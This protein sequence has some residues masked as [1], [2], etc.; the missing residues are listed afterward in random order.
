MRI[1]F[2][3]VSTRASPG[4]RPVGRPF[5]LTRKQVLLEA[6]RKGP[7]GTVLTATQPRTVLPEGQSGDDGG[8]N[9][10]ET[11]DANKDAFR[12][13]LEA[14]KLAAAVSKQAPAPAPA[15]AAGDRPTAT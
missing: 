1:D 13:E 7:P 10:T 14:K 5:V 9:A 2:D 4:V 15:P 8:A 6:V 12:Q 11:K 3:T